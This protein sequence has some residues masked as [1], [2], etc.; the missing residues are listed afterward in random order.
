M[1][2]RVLIFSLIISFIVF[3]E[4]RS[5]AQAGK[6]SPYI[7]INLTMNVS[8]HVNPK[9]CGETIIRH[10]ELLS[11]Y[12]AKADYA[13]TGIVAHALAE[14]SPETIATIKR[15]G[16]PLGYHHRPPHPT[17][18]EAVEGKSWDEAVEIMWNFE[19]Q[20]RDPLRGTLDPNRV[21]G[22]KGVKEIFGITPLMGG[23]P[24]AAL[25]VQRKMGAR[26]MVNRSLGTDPEKPPLYWYMGMLT[27]PGI[28][29]I[30]YSDITA[31]ARSRENL[32]YEIKKSLSGSSPRLPADPE[33]ILAHQ[34]ARLPDNKITFVNTT[35]HTSDFYMLGHIVDIYLIRGRTQNPPV[36]FSPPFRKKEDEE[37]MWNAFE[38]FIAFCALNKRIKPV[39]SVDILGMVEPLQEVQNINLDKILKTAEYINDR[40][41]V[42]GHLPEYIPMGRSYLSL[43]DAFQVLSNTLMEYEK[44]SKLPANVSIKELLG[45]VRFPFS[46]QMGYSGGLQI[47][48]VVPTW[49]PGNNVVEK[50]AQ[51]SRETRD[52]IPGGVE[53]ESDVEIWRINPAQF[54][55]LMVQTVVQINSSGFP[56]KALLMSLNSPEGQNWTLKPAVLKNE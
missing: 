21:G 55:Y 48:P 47:A 52:A 33:D 44:S 45:P 38:E 8:D 36:L 32:R 5:V 54:L 20:K 42:R 4:N 25:Y 14:H 6:V 50:A 41:F 31:Q 49:M 29:S 7:L 24:A 35:L 37:R 27:R 15:L 34:I 9:K 56:G 23:G 53:I 22:F 30:M 3:A 18:Q 11:K 2:Y 10:A 51:I 40:T 39:T 43:S 17:A 46:A 13:F 28:F 16:I 26:M 1:Y 19:T 12:G